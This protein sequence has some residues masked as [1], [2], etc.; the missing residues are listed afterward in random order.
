MLPDGLIIRRAEP[1]DAAALAAFGARTFAETFGA[2]NSPEDLSA[3]L[4]GAYGEPQQRAEFADSGIVTLVVERR[5]EGSPRHGV[6][7]FSQLRRGP[8]P[9][10]VALPSPVELWRF[11]VDR[12]WHGRGVAHALMQVALDAG[13]ELGGASVWLSVWERNPRAI[14]FYTKCGFSDVGSKV[15]MV[16]GDPQTDRVMARAIAHSP[17]V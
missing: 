10:C 9:P 5:D 15:F 6:V 7:A 14:V 12:V 3:Y 4:A 11:Y 1:G 17:T 16:G 8:A 13:L 2:D